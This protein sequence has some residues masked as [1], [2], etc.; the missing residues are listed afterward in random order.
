MR[1]GQNP[2]KSMDSVVG[3]APTTVLVISHIPFLAGYYAQSLEILKR[4][5][6]S[7][8]E[9]TEAKYD[10]MLFDN[11]SCEEVRGFLLEQEDV[12]NIDFLLLTERNLGKSGAWNMAF[13][14]AP[15]E[16]IAY[17]DS[18]VYFHPGWLKPHLD[19]LQAFPKTGMVTGMP[20]LTP[21]K[22]STKTIDW[23][24]S[25]KD[26]KLER[27]QF[28]SWEEFW[29][30]ASSLGDTEEK[31]KTFYANNESIQIT[32]EGKRYF[33][34]AG[35]FQFVGRKAILQELLPFPAERPMGRV[36]ML[37]EMMNQKSYLRLSLPDWH[38]HHMGNTIPEDL[39][40]SPGV[41]SRPYGGLWQWK[42]LRKLLQRFYDRIFHIL[43]RSNAR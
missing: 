42:P 6:G 12:G 8:R 23:A 1:V 2:V 41:G 20:L 18:D 31:A 29:R 16:T 13:A 32:R 3:P 40:F 21:E 27:G 36:R 28:I 22:Y 33:V 14:A 7:I 10:L 24:A 39:S 11:A 26:V 35:H 25:Q 4:C 17:A 37:D 9:N 5:L 38:V 34:G 43:Y 19:A 15:G 30:H